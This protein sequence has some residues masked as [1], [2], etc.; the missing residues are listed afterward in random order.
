MGDS[1]TD[2]LLWIL[3]NF[4]EHLFYRIPLGDC[5]CI[6]KF[7]W[8]FPNSVF[9]LVIIM[10]WDKLQ[11]FDLVQIKCTS[12][13]LKLLYKIPSMPYPAVVITWICNTLF[14]PLPFLLNEWCLH[15]STLEKIDCKLLE[16]PDSCK[17]ISCILPTKFH[18]RTKALSAT[19]NLL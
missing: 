6:L 4:L 19:L 16:S 3:G 1:D 12:T 18:D 2:V 11:D 9:I 5:F 14:F 7:V 17:K 10:A 15:L 13:S 8:Y